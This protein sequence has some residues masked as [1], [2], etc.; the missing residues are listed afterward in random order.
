MSTHNIRFEYKNEYHNKLSQICSQGMFSQGLKNEFKT[1]VV[2]ESSAFE[3][4]QFYCI[5]STLGPLK[6]L[7]LL[8]SF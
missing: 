7:S 2:N 5:L 8:G 6:A 1:A 4:L 3:P